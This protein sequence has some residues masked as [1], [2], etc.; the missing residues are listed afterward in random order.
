M[1]RVAG[2]KRRIATGLAVPS[3]AGLSP[4]GVG[5]GTAGG[6]GVGEEHMEEIA[7]AGSA[8]SRRSATPRYST[9]RFCARPWR[10]RNI[11]IVSSEGR[12]WTPTPRTPA[13]GF[14]ARHLLPILTPLAVDPAPP[15]PT[16]RVFRSTFAVLVRNP[17]RQGAFPRV[18]V[19]DQLDRMVSVDGARAANTAAPR[20]PLIPL[21]DIIA[22]HLDTLF[23]PAWRLWSTTSSA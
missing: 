18:K 22:E 21:E 13:P 17:D 9:S 11:R 15:F 19:P 10:N 12:I 6:G 5:G 16:S 8:P 1:V 23:P 3:A 7:S 2:L 20:E 4:E 14:H